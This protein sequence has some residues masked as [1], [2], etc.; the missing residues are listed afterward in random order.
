[1]ED[2]STEQTDD[3]E[4]TVDETIMPVSNSRAAAIGLTAVTTTIVA[5][6][7]LTAPFLRAFTGAP[8][9]ASAHAARNALNVHLGAH[10]ATLQAAKPH[11]RPAGKPRM[12]D[13][14]SGSGELVLDA[15]RRGYNAIGYERNLWLVLLSRYRA[16]RRGLHRHAHFVCADLWSVPLHRFDAVVVFGVPSIMA[17][18]AQKVRAE[19]QDGCLVCSN[20]FEI[21]G[22]PRGQR[23]GGVWFYSV[24]RRAPPPLSPS[25]GGNDDSDASQ[26]G[27]EWK[28]VLL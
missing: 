8:Y 9:V 7:A 23:I 28:G 3:L 24:W 13:L 10:A 22:L 20:S 11:V 2:S 5:L 4:W 12:V 27:R 1:M 15:A 14:G 16:Y 21:V 25:A 26:K 19:C 6:T 18:V 17:R